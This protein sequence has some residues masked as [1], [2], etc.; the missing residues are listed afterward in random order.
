MKL[1]RYKSNNI[2]VNVLLNILMLL[3]P[4]SKGISA[5]TSERGV[6]NQRGFAGN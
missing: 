2:I 4:K 3:G 1:F 6:D 5:T